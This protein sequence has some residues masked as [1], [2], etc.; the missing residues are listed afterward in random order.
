MLLILV[1]VFILSIATN[2][3]DEPLEPSTQAWLDYPG[4]TAPEA[5]NGY[6]ALLAL[7]AQ[8]AQPIAA[9]GTLM[10]EKRAI[11]ADT[12][13]SQQ[14]T[15][16]PYREIRTRLLNPTNT[17]IPS[18]PDCKDNCYAYLLSHAELLDNLSITHAELI[19]RYSAML[20]FPAYTEEM[21][22][23]ASKPVYPNYRLA[24]GLG[25]L[26]LGKAVFAQQ[27]GDA[28]IAYQ[29]WVRHQRFWQMAAAGSVSLHSLLEAITQIERGQKFLAN[30]LASHPDSVTTARL[31]IL[32]V[33]AEHSQLAPLLTRNLMYEFQRQAYALTNLIFQNSL[34]EMSALENAQPAKPRDRLALL[35]Y[36]RNTSLN[37][38]HRLYQN[39]M[40]QNSIVLDRKFPQENVDVPIKTA[41]SN[42]LDWHL[43]SNLTGKLMLCSEFSYDFRH[44]YERVAKAEAVA[45]ELNQK[46]QAMH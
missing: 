8:V 18:L 34:F 26:Y 19:K 6:L 35:F 2:R 10:R 15:P 4:L 5:N 44:Y 42:S 24:Q 36:Q 27:K 33:L 21:P 20:D 39:S 9:A 38:L 40:S 43:L 7:D 46:I 12:R 41:C 45:K 30:M 3:F 22:L 17:H 16:Q 11:F 1:A 28:Q 14:Y 25:L 31:H 23:V 37:L 13:K 32:P 29:E